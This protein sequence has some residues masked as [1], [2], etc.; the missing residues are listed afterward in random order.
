MAGRLYV[1]IELTDVQPGDIVSWKG[2]H[3]HH[4]KVKEVSKKSVIIQNHPNLKPTTKRV[5]RSQIIECWRWH[6]KAE[7]TS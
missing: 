6:K 4:N 1:S 3:L 7:K 5:N 2:R